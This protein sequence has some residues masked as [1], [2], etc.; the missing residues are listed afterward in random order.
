MFDVKPRLGEFS[1]EFI[2]LKEI[3]A[4]YD[5]PW[6]MKAQDITDERTSSYTLP[7]DRPYAW[8]NSVMTLDGIL[9]FLDP[10]S[11]VSDVALKGVMDIGHHSLA[12]FRL[13]NSGWS[14]ADGV[15]IT[16]EILR[17]EPEA[18][19]IVNFDD[20]RQYR[21]QTLGHEHADPINFVLTE[22][23]EIDFE[24][25]IFDPTKKLRI[26]ILTTV[27]GGQR[28]KEKLMVAQRWKRDWILKHV[29]GES[30]LKGACLDDV[31]ACINMNNTVVVTFE[32]PPPSP[33][34]RNKPRTPTDPTETKGAEA[35]K[36]SKL[37]LRTIFHFLR[38]NLDVKH[39]DV[40][41]GGS[42]IRSLIDLKLLDE[43][44]FTQ[45]GQIA[46]GYAADGSARPSL[47]HPR[48]FQVESYNSSETPLIA[49][50]GIRVIGEHLMFIRGQIEYRH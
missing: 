3:L 31:K 11:T 16:G 40:S 8:S 36:G 41:A 27:A 38:T 15:L 35:R 29:H 34:T 26:V 1:N 22:S 7:E 33:S 17:N 37:D 12:D 4:F 50:K 45:A 48:S 5:I 25:S 44:R 28:A 21:T 14:F 18:G 13:L 39:L 19:C 6:L 9:H 24:H 30:S 10:G 23:C 32:A 46:G 2:P 49:W 20:L 42:V 47:F 43:M